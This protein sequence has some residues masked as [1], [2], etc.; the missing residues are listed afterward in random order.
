MGFLLPPL[1]SSK[2]ANLLGV[3]SCLSEKLAE[4]GEFLVFVRGM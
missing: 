2:I 1:K 4:F 3:R